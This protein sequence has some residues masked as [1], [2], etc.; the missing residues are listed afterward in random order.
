MPP[1]CTY[2]LRLKLL[3]FRVQFLLAGVR[4]LRQYFNTIGWVKRTKSSLYKPVPLTPVLFR[5]K[6]KKKIVG[7][8][9]T[10]VQLENG[11]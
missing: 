5:N 11:E 7:D 8:W 10:K 6:Q 1:Y 4:S 9:L 2:I 3:Q